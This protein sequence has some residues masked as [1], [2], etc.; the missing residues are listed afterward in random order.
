MARP[1]AIVGY[2]SSCQREDPSITLEY[3]EGFAPGQLNPYF[4]R[5]KVL[6][7]S[8]CVGTPPWKVKIHDD[9]HG[10]WHA[11]MRTSQAIQ[12]KSISNP[13]SSTRQ[14]F[15]SIKCGPS[16]VLQQQAMRAISSLVATQELQ[17]LDEVGGVPC[18]WVIGM[19]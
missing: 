3:T 18:F 15:L 4:K 12:L 16:K 7:C 8:P 1:P 13:S 6:E 19:F 17:L 11:G 2:T 9:S 10:V 5:A 14:M